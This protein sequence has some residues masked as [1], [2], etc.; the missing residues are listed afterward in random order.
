MQTL[1]DLKDPSESKTGVHELNNIQQDLQRSD[2]SIKAIPEVNVLHL[3]ETGR[4]TS[5]VRTK[6]SRDQ[7]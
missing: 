6:R 3:C 5:K 7:K 2:I 1:P 4:E